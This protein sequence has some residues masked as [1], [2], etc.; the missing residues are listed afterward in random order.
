MHQYVNPLFK[1]C[2]TFLRPLCEIRKI[3]IDEAKL[4]REGLLAVLFSQHD[5]GLELLDFI[6]LS[7]R[8]V[9]EADDIYWHQVVERNLQ[10]CFLLLSLVGDRLAGIADGTIDKVDCPVVLCP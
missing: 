7:W 3:Q 8:K 9:H 1:I 2:Y 4:V 5:I 6:A 10:L